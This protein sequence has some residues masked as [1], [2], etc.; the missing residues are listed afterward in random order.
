VDTDDGPVD[1]V[2]S[3]IVFSGGSISGDDY[4]DF[5]IAVGKLPDAPQL[6]FKVLQTYSDG[7]VVRWIEEGSDT[8]GAA[9]PEH[10]APTIKLAPAA[11][12]PDAAPSA[13]PGAGHGPSV[14]AAAAAKDGDYA[15]KNE[16][17]VALAVGIAGAV[18]GL[19][20]LGTA[21]AKR[22]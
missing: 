18:L 6:V 3:K 2:V 16:V 21:V 4:V 15:S 12:D 19:L 10:P 11:A 14:S 9:E 5:P 20:G 13:S 1:S 17:R 8:P 7:N 22:R